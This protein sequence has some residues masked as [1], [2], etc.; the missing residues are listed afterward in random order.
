MYV[1][2]VYISS[3]C[4]VFCLSSLHFWVLEPPG[5]DGCRVTFFKSLKRSLPGVSVCIHKTKC[6]RCDGDSGDAGWDMGVKRR[7]RQQTGIFLSLLRQNCRQCLYMN[8]AT[9]D[10]L[11]H[12]PWL[13]VRFETSFQSRWG[14]CIYWRHLSIFFCKLRNLLCRLESHWPPGWSQLSDAF[15]CV[16]MWVVWNRKTNVTLDS[17]SLHVLLLW[18]EQR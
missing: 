7:K 3:P 10:V 2:T 17:H 13:L 8:L 15:D 4:F 12:R 16:S 11:E 5:A 14:V 6:V 1:Y 9:V 18:S